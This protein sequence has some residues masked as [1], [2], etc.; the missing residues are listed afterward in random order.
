MKRFAPSIPRNSGFDRG[1]NCIIDVGISCAGFS[2]SSD[3][4]FLLTSE[5]TS[6][7]L[8]EPWDD[9]LTSDLL[10]TLVLA[11]KDI[12]ILSIDCEL[13]SSKVYTSSL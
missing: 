11:G 3:H 9:E 1:I 13:L 2:T 7:L 4:P 12:S 8:S 10:Q 5:A 6:Y